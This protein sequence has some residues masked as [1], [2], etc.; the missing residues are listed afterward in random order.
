MNFERSKDPKRT[1]RIGKS[2]LDE[3]KEHPICRSIN[4][5]MK[6]VEDPRNF[7][8][9]WINPHEQFAFHSAWCTEQDLRD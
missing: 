2:V 7:D 9:V 4:D 3:L 8:K 6:D 5:P 1:L